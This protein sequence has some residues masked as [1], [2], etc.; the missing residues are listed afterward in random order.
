MAFEKILAVI[1][2]SSKHAE[3][4]VDES[5]SPTTVTVS[6]YDLRSVCQ[7]LHTHPDTYFDMLSCLT[8]IDNGPQAST[9]EV[10]YTLYSIPYHRHLNLRVI[11]RRDEPVIDSIAHIWRT[12]NWHEREAFDMLGIHFTDHPDLRRILMPADWAGYP[13][14]KDY[15]QE[16]YYRDIKIEY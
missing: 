11:L 4:A 13:L 3:P 7:S 12:A 14:R 1:K 9:V 15:Q 8:G 6:L 10:V 5:S 16:G 2:E